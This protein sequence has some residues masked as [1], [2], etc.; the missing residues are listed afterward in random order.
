[1]DEEVDVIDENDNLLGFTKMKSQ[2]H[3][4][5][6]W[7]RAAHLWV[8]IGNKI[9]MQKR[10]PTKYTFPNCFDV[11]CA[12]H[13]IAGE[14]YEKTI[15]RELEEELGIK[16]NKKDFIYTGKRKLISV[17]KGKVKSREIVA[18]Y[19]Y[20]FRGKL[21]DIKVQEEEISEVKLFGINELKD[22][23]KTK[24]GLFAGPEKAEEK[25]YFWE[26]IDQIED[27]IK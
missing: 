12:G 20:R 10:A 3:K 24:P 11:A 13:V 27:I 14:S 1:M 6:D 5:G 22:L 26:M 23:I 9:L 17:E 15:E 21:S 16:A 2:V 18:V 4:D 19:I 7:H 8:I 25:D